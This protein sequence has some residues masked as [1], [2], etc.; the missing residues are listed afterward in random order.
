ML[1]N[2]RLPYVTT[3]RKEVVKGLSYP[4][5]S[6]IDG[7]YFSISYDKKTIIDGLKQLIFTQKGERVMNPNFGTTLK[8]RVFGPLD[9]IQIEEIKLELQNAIRT[10]EPRVSIE[11]LR[12]GSLAEGNANYNND[13][14]AI[15]IQMLLRFSDNIGKVEVVSLVYNG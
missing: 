6:G 12:V 7:G 9:S 10:Y 2:V 11:E 1:F 8:S 15:S 4:M 5:L 14:Y 3:S 13:S